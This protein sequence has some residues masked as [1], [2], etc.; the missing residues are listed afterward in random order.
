MLQAPPDVRVLMWTALVSLIIII[1]SLFLPWSTVTK[2]ISPETS[3]QVVAGSATGGN[4][5]GTGT[6]SNDS[7]SAGQATKIQTTTTTNSAIS[8]LINDWQDGQLNY[9]I[10]VFVSTGISLVITGYGFT[11]SPDYSRYSFY[12]F[13]LGLVGLIYIIT[14]ATDIDVAVRKTETHVWNMGFWLSFVGFIGFVLQVYILRKTRMGWLFITPVMF[15]V[16]LF[17]LYPAIETIR[18]SFYDGSLAKPTREFVGFDNFVRLFT[19]DRFFLKNIEF[20]GASTPPIWGIVV[21]DTP[22]G[23]LINTL[24]WLILFPTLTVGIGLLIAVLT[25]QVRYESIVKSI[26]FMPMVISATASSIIFRFVYHPDETIGVINALLSQIIPNFDPIAFLGRTD[27]ANYAV[28][29]AG[30][31]IWTGLAMIVT[32]A[33]Y[34]A[35]PKEV[36]EAARVDGAG[37]WQT[38]WRVQLPMMTG[39]ISFI[40]ITMVINALKMLDLVLVMTRDGSPRGATR[41]IG[42]AV[43]RELFTNGEAGYASAIAVVLL[44]MT[45]PFMY[46]QLRRIQS[47][48]GEVGNGS[49]PRL[50]L[51][52]SR[53]QIVAMVAC[54][55]P[56]VLGIHILPDATKLIPIYL[57][58]IAIVGGAIGAYLAGRYLNEHRALNRG[59]VLMAFILILGLYHVLHGFGFLVDVQTLAEGG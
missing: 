51:N 41:I 31:W 34:K 26:I 13:L 49:R 28:I 46:L 6:T 7:G 16:F 56:L 42:F 50:G 20:H 39:P 35:L 43:F 40:I 55:I 8:L 48:S 17:L 58:P 21:T 44:I 10:L 2:S 27:L 3:Q 47:E 14:K 15:L 36:I 23:T 11:R 53:S 57:N 1:T 54:A 9:V 30:V 45:L 18:I 59:M 38:F 22:A 52:L 5:F 12:L 33:A 25:D 4:P 37:R 29:W 19:R 32:S 24:V